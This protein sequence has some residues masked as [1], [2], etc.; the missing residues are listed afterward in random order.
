MRVRVRR[1]D[2]GEKHVESKLLLE[3]PF[4]QKSVPLGQ[5]VRTCVVIQDTTHGPGSLDT[6][7]MLFQSL[8]YI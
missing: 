1:E 8:L 3:I 2:T 4:H 6:S 7:P 5:E